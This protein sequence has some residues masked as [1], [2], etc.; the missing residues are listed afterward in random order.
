MPAG[1]RRHGRMDLNKLTVKTRATLD[2][3]HQ[4]SR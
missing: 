2:A 1:P 3:A 4:L